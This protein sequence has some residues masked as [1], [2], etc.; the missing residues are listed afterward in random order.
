MKKNKVIFILLLELMLMGCSNAE[1]KINSEAVMEIDRGN[2]IKA[3]YLLNDAI[4]IN[5]DYLDGMVN[6]RNVYP[7]ALDQA[8]EK[9]GEYQ[10]VSDYKLE[11]YAYEDLLKL[12]NNYYYADDLVHQK[13][14][15][16]LEILTIEELYKLKATMGEVYYSAGNELEDR[17]LNRAEKRERYFLYERGVE[18]S[19]KYK[20]LADRR[21]KAYE[22]ALVKAM[23]E[24]SKNTPVSYRINLES[25]VKGNVAQGEKRTLIRL[26]PLDGKRFADAWENNKADNIINTGIKINLN[27]ITSTPESVKKSVIPLTWYEQYVANTKDGPVVKNIKKTYFRHDFYKSADVRVSFTYIMKDLST[28]EII[29]SG[30]F[31]GIGEDSYG[32]SDF[33]G[34]LPKGQARGTY[35]RKL[36]S[37]KE[38][39]EMALADAVSKISQDISDK[40]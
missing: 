38:L 23:I 36:K 39:T 9:I 2:F 24:F 22:E 19:P 33:S 28:G 40:I 35:V 16:S 29:G 3:S 31:D 17:K 20:D 21:E 27:Y 11:A 7:R 25:Q 34:N 13:L 5:P 18:L 30:T 15:L 10:K 26:V 12:K 4:R 37:K 32:W 14:S 1:E 8:V 6:Y